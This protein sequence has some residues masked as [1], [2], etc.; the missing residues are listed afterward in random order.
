MHTPALLMCM[1]Q[2]LKENLALSPYSGDGDQRETTHTLMSVL[3]T[4]LEIALEYLDLH[5]TVDKQ[6][7]CWNGFS[8]GSG[9]S[10]AYAYLDKNGGKYFTLFMGIEGGL[11]INVPFIAD[12]VHGKYGETPVEGC[13]FYLWCSTAD[14]EGVTCERV[15]KSATILK[16]R[17]GVDV[18]VTPDGGHMLWNNSPELQGDAVTLWMNC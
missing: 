1:K 4:I 5:Y 12:L 8:R 17:G 18:V 14:K 7:S 3:P 2:H 11:N 10:I 6:L 16:E 9:S 13:Y 15:T